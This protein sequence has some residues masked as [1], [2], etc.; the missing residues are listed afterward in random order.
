MCAKKSAKKNIN[1][2]KQ[3]F[4]KSRKMIKIDIMLSIIY[5]YKVYFSLR[6]HCGIVVVFP[7][8]RGIQDK[9]NVVC[10][11]TTN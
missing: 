1:Y 10:F 2:Y 7:E 4:F 6:T 9:A 3:I 5:Y 11:L 8:I